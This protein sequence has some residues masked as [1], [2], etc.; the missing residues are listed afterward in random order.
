MDPMIL[1]IAAD[2][3]VYGAE[4][5][6]TEVTLRMFKGAFQIGAKRRAVG[7][8]FTRSRNRSHESHSEF[9]NFVIKDRPLRDIEKAWKQIAEQVYGLLKPPHV[10][11]TKL[12]AAQIRELEGDP[13][14]D[15][16]DAIRQFFQYLRAEISKEP[17]LTQEGAFQHDEVILTNINQIKDALGVDVDLEQ[18]E[19]KVRIAAKV[20]ISNFK[21][22]VRWPDISVSLRLRTKD[23]N[24]S[25]IGLKDIISLVDVGHQVIIDAG[26]GAG[27]TTTLIQLADDLLND[28][29][30]SIPL[31]IPLSKWVY[32]G[33]DCFDYISRRGPF[34][35]GLS[36]N[37]LRLL[38]AH[39]RLMFCF[40]GWNELSGDKQ[41]KAFV[42]LQ[43]LIQDYPNVG[44][45]LTSRWQ[46]HKTVLPNPLN[47]NLR[48]LT[49]D[50]RTDIINSNIGIDADKHL[51]HIRTHRELN[52][53][54]LT[55][56][57][58]AT[59]VSLAGQKR[60]P[61]SKEQLLSAF[62]NKHEELEEHYAALKKV[63][64]EYH[65]KY[66][67]ALAFNMTAFE[68]T[69]LQRDNARE[70][71]NSVRKV[72]IEEGLISVGP[73]P[74][75]VLD[76]LCG[77]HLLVKF[78]D[79]D[80]ELYS[81]V[82]HQFQEW[83]ASH[84][85]E[86]MIVSAAK[87]ADEKTEQKLR[88]DIIDKR[89]WEEPLF[90]ANER[91]VRT[92]EHGAPAVAHVIILTL[93][94]DP[95]FA[96]SMIRLAG[97]PVWEIISDKILAFALRWHAD[98]KIDRALRFMVTTGRPEFSE[99]IWPYISNDD[100]DTRLKALRV[101]EPF[102]SSVLGEDW[103]DTYFSHIEEIRHDIAS[104]FAHQGGS[105]DALDA[106]MEIANMD[107]SLAIRYS[108]LEGLAFRGRW[109]CFDTVL[110][111]APE[112]LWEILV[113]NQWPASEVKGTHYKR[114]VETKI[115]VFEELTGE[116]ARTQ[117]LLDLDDMGWMEAQSLIFQE[118]ENEKLDI[119]NEVT[120]SL[121]KRAY[122]KD[123]EATALAII[124]RLITGRPVS[125]RWRE[126]LVIADNGV[127]SETFLSKLVLSISST[128]RKLFRYKQK[129]NGY[130]STLTIEEHQNLLSSLLN[131]EGQ[132]TDS[133]K[134]LAVIV[135]M[136]DIT[137]LLNRMDEFSI[138]IAISEQPYPKQ[139]ADAKQRVESILD[140]TRFT[141]LL[142]A[143]ISLPTTNSPY[144]AADYASVLTSH[145]GGRESEELRLLVPD[146][147]YAELRKVISGWI[148]VIK[149]DTERPRER[150]AA[151]ITLIGRLGRSEDAA[152]LIELLDL[153]IEARRANR[154]L[155]R[156]GQH[157]PCYLNRYQI[158]FMAM[159]Y[160]DVGERI[161]PYLD[162]P[163]FTGEAA[164]ILWKIIRYETGQDE[165][166]YS[167]YPDYTEVP[168][169][170]EIRAQQNEFPSPHPY[171]L[172]ILERIRT[173][174]K[175]AAEPFTA[176]HATE[177]ASIIA[178]MNYGD[179]LDLLV[180][181]LSEDQ[182]GRRSYYGF[183]RLVIAGESVPVAPILVGYKSTYER[184]EQEAWKKDDHWFMIE[185]WLELLI[186]SDTPSE[187]FT[188]TLSLAQDFAGPHRFNRLTKAL[189]YC[190]DPSAVN[191]LKELSEAIPDLYASKE[192]SEALLAIGTEEAAEAL[193]DVLLSP[194]K[195]NLIEHGF[196]QSYFSHS[197]AH[198]MMRFP[199][200]QI[201]ILKLINSPLND[202]LRNIISE[203]L[204][205]EVDNDFL[206]ASLNL[207]ND[208]SA[209]MF[210]YTLKQALEQRVTFH[211]PLDESGYMYEIEPAKAGSIRKHL[212]WMMHNDENRKQAAHH[213][214][215][216]IDR[217]RD[218]H[219]NH[220]EET[221]HPDIASGLP[222]P[223]EAAE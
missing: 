1:K 12:L 213:V 30:N 28:E 136:N 138:E 163:E 97:E 85:V 95:M 39:G 132:L 23:K 14:N 183:L 57:Y 63:L 134:L 117:C 129:G 87:G 179:N 173:L 200:I 75:D 35:S 96:S 94:I 207:L 205:S 118:L 222:W 59:F 206:L 120:N 223:I 78:D 45:V 150:M 99:I 196:R 147:L 212:F 42:M 8:A 114:L 193:V 110:A 113:S 32:G 3:L 195:Y 122:G 149:L 214:L 145:D 83:Y 19:K 29:D 157:E 137:L 191:V 40:D 31:F 198:L 51:E 7:R 133:D 92:N 184:W 25:D 13:P 115:K 168:K 98:E 33:H 166:G 50:Q 24:S 5:V 73:E 21:S 188:R 159:P 215:E 151:V 36:I 27:K 141:Q 16:E 52:E 20:H 91:L 82:H 38:G 131:G 161:L 116:P 107:P 104:E 130:L 220:M 143:I 108:I 43:E 65:D 139:I 41:H 100:Q 66:L 125:R 162:V 176:G 121:I 58:L 194:D 218:R 221:R 144:N 9:W 123:R 64:S 124:Q 204:Q 155:A 199:A 177:L 167:Q 148:E 119:T 102:F 181:A 4:F 202:Q 15:F 109:G 142:K 55:P 72:L 187:G 18:T 71:V 126:Y 101:T 172:A 93:S 164:R 175:T 47:V 209:Q 2:A 203:M 77:H 88:E 56:L 68:N 189:G 190:S 152:I 153:E 201:K 74:S 62:V 49:N 160:P 158:A 60:L 44:V 208:K 53:I 46:V 165:E 127:E 217:K 103:L 135:D 67:Q 48:K 6:A 37:H 169:L 26:P 90:F 84:D 197:L 17:D 70:T 22:S 178:H 140:H 170:R 69:E 10:P 80:D 111:D 146:N 81:F 210:P 61:E 171:A 182:I 185:Q 11:N 89:P 86:Q 105:M 54:T 154:E 128:I 216:W 156:G 112:E 106:V 192:W 34:A 76:T 211:R 180:K 219:G 79:G 174:L 186:L